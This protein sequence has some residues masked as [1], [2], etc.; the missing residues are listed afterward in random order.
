VLN[1]SGSAEHGELRLPAPLTVLDAISGERF[2]GSDAITLPMPAW[3][4]RMLLVERAS[5]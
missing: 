2:E 5:P 4:C 3:G 1:H